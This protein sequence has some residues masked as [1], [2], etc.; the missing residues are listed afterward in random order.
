MTLHD[1]V[2]RLLSRLGVLKQAEIF[3]ID[4]TLLGEQLPIDE[5]F[6]KGTADQHHDHTGRFSRLQQSQGL[7]Q[8]VQ[9]A[10]SAGKCHQG[11]RTEQ[12]MHLP[13]GEIA[14]LKTQGPE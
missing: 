6:P 13:Q 10:E 7:K 12:K 9:R 4:E 14:E 2:P 8:L 3:D 5:A 11:F 1:Q